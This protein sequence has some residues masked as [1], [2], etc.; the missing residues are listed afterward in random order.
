MEIQIFLPAKSKVSL[1]FINILYIE[2]IIIKCITIFSFADI[3]LICGFFAKQ[4]VLNVAI[5][6]GYIFIT[7]IGILTSKPGSGLL[8]FFLSI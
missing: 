1:L 5:D 3:P 6:N 8:V 7:L 2:G 4:M